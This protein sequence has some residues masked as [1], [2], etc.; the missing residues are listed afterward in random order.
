MKI[1][2]INSVCG[3]GS[4]GRICTDLY[5]FLTKNG[6]EVLVC[7]GR[8][9]DIKQINS[10][11]ISNSFFNHIDGIMTRIFDNHGL[12]SV[13]STI[14]L[15]IIMKKFKPDIV[16]LHNLHGYY[17]NFKILFK[18]IKKMNLKVVWTLHDTWSFTGHCTHYEYARC[19][20]W[21]SGCYS[22]P[23]KKEYP[24][25]I[26]FDNSRGM[27]KLKKKEFTSISNLVLIVPSRW[28]CNQVS[29]SF[30]NHKP[31][32]INNG[33]D[34]SIFKRNNNIKKSNIV[35]LGVCSKWSLKKGVYDFFKL[36]RILSNNKNVII[37]MVGIKKDDIPVD[38]TNI[39]AIDKTNDIYSLVGLYNE[40]DVFFN[41]TYEDTFPTVNLESLCC[42]TPVATYDSGGSTEIINQINGIVFEKGD[43]EGFIR[44]LSFLKNLKELYADM[45]S[46]NA[47]N[48]YNKEL[49]YN[50]YLK[51]YQMLVGK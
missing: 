40:A 42:G 38:I 24:K 9:S 20:K 36:A 29:H 8:Y 14:K 7:Y 30:F 18:Y 4:T 35:I 10:K 5:D 16:H 27:Y 13:L 6:H 1:L 17:I 33:I 26:F 48:L 12:N 28:L 2:I 37:K 43:V 22:C 19:S 46:E 51:V 45:I 15:V 50:K 47:H 11:K 41:P 3:I 31:L 44:Q 34:I 23:Q 32:I 49:A 25:S 21:I 39:V